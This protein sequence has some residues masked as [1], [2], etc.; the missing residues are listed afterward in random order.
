MIFAVEDSYEWHKENMLRNRSH[1]SF[2]ANFGPSAVAA[3]QDKVGA[4]VYF[5]PFVELNGSVRN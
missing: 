2:V 4:E 1:Y 3:L 5:N